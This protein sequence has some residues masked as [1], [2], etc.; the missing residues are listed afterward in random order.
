MK[1]LYVYNGC[2][3]DQ[4]F[5]ELGAMFSS[6]GAD[7]NF[8]YFDPEDS[9]EYFSI[10]EEVLRIGPHVVHA[11]ALWSPLFVLQIVSGIPTVVQA[12]D[13]Y[14]GDIRRFFE[15]EPRKGQ[16]HDRL[17]AFTMSQASF[18]V[19]S[20]RGA[21]AGL[22]VY[23]PNALYVPRP[24]GFR[25]E[26]L[27]CQEGAIG[28]ISSSELGVDAIRPAF[29]V[30]LERL[31]IPYEFDKN[32]CK[33]YSCIIICP[34]VELSADGVEHLCSMGVPI[35]R[36][37]SVKFDIEDEFNFLEYSLDDWP[38]SANKLWLSL[39]SMNED[40]YDN[41]VG[42]IKAIHDRRSIES[43][44]MAYKHIYENAVR[45]ALIRTPVRGW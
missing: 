14:N 4:W 22:K 31:R 3:D 34:G 15:S 39:S 28:V 5:T 23:A 45:K 44:Y 26:G 10:V 35:A 18:L 6:R 8:V 36:P 16:T 42:K 21:E 24:I 32:L 40:I 13:N 29:D 9:E 20:N 43:I 38:E 19:T 41:E 37:S 17:R 12:V 11:M 27:A 25:Y 1:I 33:S 30:E 7:V 2:E